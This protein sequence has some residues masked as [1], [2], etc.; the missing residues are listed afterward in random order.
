MSTIALTHGLRKRVNTV[1][2]TLALLAV[3][4]VA[5]A[6]P[7]GWTESVNG[8]G[9]SAGEGVLLVPQEGLAT[10]A[11]ALSFPWGMPSVPGH[12]AQWSVEV[13]PKV[14][15]CA[16]TFY[17]S[18][19]FTGPTAGYHFM[20][21]LC[22]ERVIWER[23]VAGGG[24]AA[25][26]IRVPLPAELV[27]AG[28]KMGLAF[29]LAGR[30]AVENFGVEVSVAGVQLMCED[31]MQT[32][33]PL[34]TVSGEYAVWP[35]DIELPALP[36]AGGWSWGANIVQ[37]WGATQTVAINDAESLAPRFAQEFG[38]NA[39]IMLPPDAHNAITVRRS[40]ID[41]KGITEAQFK[42]AVAAYRAQGIKLIL[43]T[44]VMHC[45]HDPQWQFGSLGVDRPEWS[46]RDPE[47]GTVTMYGQP[48][49]CP[50]TGALEHTLAY[51][52]SL[53]EKYDC[54]AVMLDNSEFMN[55][56]AGRPTCYCA[57]CR[58]K[59]PKYVLQRFGE[60]G[61]KDLL[62]LTPEQVQIPTTQDDPLWGLWLSWRNRVWGEAMETYRERLRKIKPDI[63]VLANTQYRYS[64]WVL[65]V[66]GQYAHEDA[67]LAE[68]R[69]L[70]ASQMAAKMTLGRALAQ[71]RPL[72]NYIGTFDDSDFTRLRPPDEVTG[73]VAASAAAGANPWIVF[74]GF[75]GEENQASLKGMTG[76]LRFWRDHSNLFVLGQDRGD[77][78]VLMSP[79]SRD[80][81]GETM[82]PTWL[83]DILGEGYAA[84]GLW[85]PALCQGGPLSQLRVI[86]ATSGACMR[87]ST[88]RLL[89]EWVADGGTLIIKMATGRRDE[90]GR[91]RSK[92]ALIDATSR[93]VNAPGTHTVGDGKVICVEADADIPE[94]IRRVT[95][96][97]LVADLPVSVFW[98]D[99]GDHGQAI[100]MALHEPGPQA[101]ELALPAG[102]RDIQ[103]MQPGAEPVDLH[104][105]ARDGQTVVSFEMTERLGV[106]SFSAP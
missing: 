57:S 19:T 12:F 44:S 99:R 54:A 83:P 85:A 41:A 26:R 25:E 2:L 11:L 105:D 58:D 61:V 92:G 100:S 43:Y 38:F 35:E 80:L 47:G 15:E 22:G 31:S 66:D 70:S 74:Y 81:A 4:V 104:G 71:G 51:T 42:D 79:E 68:S 78:G 29:R 39:I 64:S 86:A 40:E 75:T 98:R 52:Q 63:V 59:F 20:Q 17:L 23:D 82:P 32:L 91:W 48:W 24:S 18:D 46:M 49:L 10:R 62:G 45:G 84:R 97:R 76:Y 106:V 14:A 50:S 13:T 96:K 27:T 55:S 72:W 5:H 90:Y 3:M 28:E 7:A 77:L 60:D 69:S 8:E 16:L 89:A 36:P 67:L 30:K 21:V 56:S 88:A 34:E 101:V 87:A 6:A 65:A 102:A 93:N 73:I 103:Y 94:A 9:F 33:L 95:L 37:P 53:V 1:A